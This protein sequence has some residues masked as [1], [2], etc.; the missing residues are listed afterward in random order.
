MNK[1]LL[2]KFLKLKI[3]ED[4]LFLCTDSKYI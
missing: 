2:T 3:S 1:I 4:V